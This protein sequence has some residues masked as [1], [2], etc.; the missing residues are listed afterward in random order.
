MEKRRKFDFILDIPSPYRLHLMAEL[1]RQLNERGY[2]FHA[3]FM[4]RGDANRPSEWRDPHIEFPH[5]Y[6]RDFGRR[7]YHFNPGLLWYLCTHR[8]DVVMCGGPYSTFTGVCVPFMAWRKDQVLIAGA[9]GNAKAPR[10]MHG[11]LGWFKRWTMSHWDYI[12]VPGEE[13]RKFIEMHQALTRR[14]M[15]V[16]AVLPNIVDETIFSPRSKW[17][18]QRVIDQ[19]EKLGLKSDEKLC[20]IPA[21]LSPEK[22]LLEFIAKLRADQLRSWRIVIVGRGMLKD[23]IIKSA[24]EL[25]IAEKVLIVDYVPYADMPL[26]YASADLFLL[27]SLRDQN[28]LSVVEALHSALP[29]AVSE[30]AGNV[31]EAVKQGRNGWVLPVRD[32]E[33]YGETLTEIFATPLE[34]LRE[35]GELSFNENAQFWNS[36]KSVARFL[37]QVLSSLK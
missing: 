8:I 1:C 23:G 3:H 12:S 36:R 17:D 27:P 5:S 16:P 6:W 34:R 15:P 18:P 10:R 29:V 24:M 13:G 21:R 22:G 20:L 28:P 14:R 19:R 25:G 9:E 37:D 11:L 26:L 2:D 32:S 7:F 33:R 30:M 4:S 35:M 31:T